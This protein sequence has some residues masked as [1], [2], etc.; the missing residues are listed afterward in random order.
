MTDINSFL[1]EAKKIEGR[2]PFL[3]GLPTSIDGKH[4][5]IG[6]G[7]CRQVAG[8]TTSAL[9]C[10]ETSKFVRQQIN[11]AIRTLQP[12]TP[13]RKQYDKLVDLLL[14]GYALIEPI[15][16]SV[17]EEV[18]YCV[19]DRDDNPTDN[20]TKM[21]FIEHVKL[22]Q[23]II[24]RKIADPLGHWNCKMFQDGFGANHDPFVRCL[25]HTLSE[26]RWLLQQ[27]LLATEHF[28]PAKMNR[29]KMQRFLSPP[30][31]PGAKRT[32]WQDA[33]DELKNRL[34]CPEGDD[35]APWTW[36]GANL[37]GFARPRVEQVFEHVDL[38]KQHCA[39][40]LLTS[41]GIG[42]TP[43][44]VSVVLASLQQAEEALRLE[45]AGSMPGQASLKDAPALDLDS[46][47]C[48]VLIAHRDW[49]DT[50]IAKHLGCNRTSLYR[51][52]EFERLRAIQKESKRDNLRKGH[53]DE[54]RGTAV[55][56]S[57]PDEDK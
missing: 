47:A 19:L 30:F 44:F 37:L 22:A 10:K 42:P 49:T 41:G 16:G 14:E 52:H 18:A 24:T 13:A 38:K 3:E 25:L 5:E 23:E 55:P 11:W 34:K 53:W 17:E 57:D 36:L 40:M 54:D 32:A 33:Y 15:A 9:K 26:A 56:H 48:A 2:C 12:G 45:T 51:L 7:W 28:L 43:P 4:A 27:S 20:P 8:W 6:E 50:R 21:S 29:K 39:H 35:A 1:K 31:M 46:R